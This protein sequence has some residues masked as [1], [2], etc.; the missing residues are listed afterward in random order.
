MLVHLVEGKLNRIGVEAG[1]VVF[2]STQFHRQMD[3]G[4]DEDDP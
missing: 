4:A 2:V 1:E 3:E